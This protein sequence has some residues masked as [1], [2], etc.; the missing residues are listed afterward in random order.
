M[1]TT[2]RVSEATRARA[3]Q[4]AVQRQVSIGEIV[5]QALDAL[6]TEQFW[7]SVTEGFER[8]ADDPEAWHDVAAE[9][10]GEASSLTDD[11]D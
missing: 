1:A 4:L 3:A 8:L 10:Q 7:V 6:E 5:E 2:L 11:L 9:R